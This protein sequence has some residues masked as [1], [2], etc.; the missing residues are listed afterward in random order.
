MDAFALQF[1]LA[2]PIATNCRGEAAMLSSSTEK[3]FLP[4]SVPFFPLMRDHGGAVKGI[5]YLAGMCVIC[6][7]FFRTCMAVPDSSTSTYGECI[8]SSNL[9]HL[10]N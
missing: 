4:E 9:S 8:T 7:E 2:I 3:Q 6:L 1:P 10:R 5:K